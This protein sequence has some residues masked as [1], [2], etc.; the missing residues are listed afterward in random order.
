[1][2]QV[3]AIRGVLVHS[4]F[5]APSQTSQKIMCCPTMSGDT[6]VHVTAILRAIFFLPQP[7]SFLLRVKYQIKESWCP[8]TS[9]HWHCYVSAC[10][11]RIAKYL[12][13]RV[14]TPPRWSGVSCT[15]LSEWIAAGWG[16]GLGFTIHS[17]PQKAPQ[18]CFQT[19]QKDKGIC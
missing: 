1:M 5:F 13:S 2:I 3:Q 7:S 15:L 14:F 18:L 11:H 17:H 12:Q 10:C 19:N 8:E 6:S 4:A 9:P 16:S